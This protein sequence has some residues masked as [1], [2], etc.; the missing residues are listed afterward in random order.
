MNVSIMNE[1]YGLIQIG[2]CVKIISESKITSDKILR[3]TLTVPSVTIGHNCT[4]IVTN[5]LDGSN[6]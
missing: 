4:E 1:K 3:I 5:K 6:K 2:I